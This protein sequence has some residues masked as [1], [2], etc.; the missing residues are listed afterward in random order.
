MKNKKSGAQ[1][2][3]ERLTADRWPGREALSPPLDEEETDRCSLSLSSVNRPRYPTHLAAD[4]TTPHDGFWFVLFITQPVN[5]HL[6][7]QRKH[8]NNQC[9]E[10]KSSFLY[11]GAASLPVPYSGT[12]VTPGHYGP[13]RLSKL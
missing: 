8:R 1:C 9:I 2:Q 4:V 11:S 6:T 3:C 13:F 5:S 12:R 7:R 10:L